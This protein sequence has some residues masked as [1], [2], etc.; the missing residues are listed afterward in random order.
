[1]I[2]GLWYT[3]KCQP[4]NVHVLIPGIPE[5][6][7]DM[8]LYGKRDFADV[9]KW[10]ILVSDNLHYGLITRILIREKRMWR[11]RRRLK[12]L[13]CWLWSWRKGHELRN[14]RTTTVEARKGKKRDSPLEPLEH[15]VLGPIKPILVFWPPEE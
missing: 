11:W 2:T 3:W 13:L 12:M 15:L 4:Q 1:M 8:T 5:T 6:C 7:E 9:T 10:Q 14:T